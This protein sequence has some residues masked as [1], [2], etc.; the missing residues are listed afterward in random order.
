M[1]VVVVFFGA[2]AR[3]DSAGAEAAAGAGAM[4]E[5]AGAAGLA[6]SPG[7]L[8]AGAVLSAAAFDFVVFFL[9]VGASAFFADAASP[10]APAFEPP[11]S[12]LAA[13]LLFDD[14]FLPVVAPVS[15]PAD[16]SVPA[17]APAPADFSVPADSPAPADFSP[18]A[19]F[20][21]FFFDFLFVV[22]L[23]VVSELALVE[24]VCALAKAGG[25]TTV[26]IKPECNH[27][28]SNLSLEAVHFSLAEM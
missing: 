8:L 9:L 1:L 27:P 18:A 2:A 6:A 20:F 4:P 13:F 28:Q 10:A 19:V 23:D 22:V 3:L 17:D 11:L 12:S 7:A 21:Y 16:F 5:L 25:I 26:I 14:F 24:L 15:L